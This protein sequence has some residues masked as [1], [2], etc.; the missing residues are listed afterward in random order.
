MSV[1]LQQEGVVQAEHMA[2]AHTTVVEPLF[3]T[4]LVIARTR[5]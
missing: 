2:V 1:A 5:V 4:G 3:P